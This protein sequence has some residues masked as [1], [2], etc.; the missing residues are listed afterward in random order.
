MR[1]RASAEVKRR[2][3]ASDTRA[4]ERRKRSRFA[5]S[6]CGGFLED[7]HTLTIFYRTR[8]IFLYNNMSHFFKRLRNVSKRTSG[9]YIDTRTRRR[10]GISRACLLKKKGQR[11][12]EHIWCSQQRHRT[13]KN[14]SAHTRSTLLPICLFSNIHL[15]F[16]ITGQ[17]RKT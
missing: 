8:A 11:D 5:V 2:S 13:S 10:N 16:D 6:G 3:R 14:Q 17:I 12:G 15:A 9:G 1:L 7:T 4:R